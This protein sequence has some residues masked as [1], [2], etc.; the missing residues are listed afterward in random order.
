M[1]C[2]SHIHGKFHDVYSGPVGTEV[3]YA[4]IGILTP[5]R[6]PFDVHV[7]YRFL[8]FVIFLQG[9][10]FYMPHLIWK[11]W[12]SDKMKMLSGGLEH[13][14]LDHVH[15]RKMLHSLIDY[16]LQGHMNGSIKY[17]VHL[18]FCELMNL[19]LVGVNIWVTDYLFQ[20][21]FVGYG[22]KALG[23][24]FSGSNK[25]DYDFNSGCSDPIKA[26][27]PQVTKCAVREVGASGSIVNHDYECILMLNDFNAN[28]FKFSW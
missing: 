12:E 8:F 1:N 3:P 9:I 2:L 26:L 22:F 7:T 21:E 11:S 23:D 28:F 16:T 6:T 15:K 18:H 19:I 5:N 4:G 27:F 25:K 14:L 17:S 10:S 24:W 13:P 20:G